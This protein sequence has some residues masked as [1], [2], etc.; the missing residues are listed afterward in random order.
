MKLIEHEHE[1]VLIKLV[2][3]EKDGQSIFE[4]SFVYDSNGYS[5]LLATFSITHWHGSQTLYRGVQP[6]AIPREDQHISNIPV[7]CT[8]FQV[9]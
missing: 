5:V 8:N 6:R 7:Y 2:I 9:N 4:I 1:L 3:R